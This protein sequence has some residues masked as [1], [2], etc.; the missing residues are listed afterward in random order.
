MGNGLW[1]SGGGEGSAGGGEA[2]TAVGMAVGGGRGVLWCTSTAGGGV[3]M[4][5]DSD[6]DDAD[7][8][9]GKADSG[10]PVDVESELVDGREPAMP[11]GGVGMREA[12]TG[13]GASSLSVSRIL[14]RA[15]SRLSFATLS[16]GALKT[17][18]A[19]VSRACGEQG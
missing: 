5:P 1:D 6:E 11:C 15:K 14:L 13:A 2:S 10:E 18:L 19:A 8:E 3:P 12:A 7:C 17:V 4:L 9:M 16:L